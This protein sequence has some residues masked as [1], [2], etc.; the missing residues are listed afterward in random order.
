MKSKCVIYGYHVK[1]DNLGHV[2]SSFNPETCRLFYPYYW[3]KNL[4][5]WTNVYGKVK[6]K[7]FR[8]GFLRGCYA[9]F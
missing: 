2:L 5:C 8:S 4:R 7:A 1:L 9:W 6:E 3:D